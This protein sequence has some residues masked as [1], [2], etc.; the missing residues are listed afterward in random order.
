LAS[1][2]QVIE[3]NLRRWDGAGK[4][5]AFGKQIEKDFWLCVVFLV[6]EQTENSIT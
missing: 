6:R 4:E 2:T 5:L 1:S 3:P